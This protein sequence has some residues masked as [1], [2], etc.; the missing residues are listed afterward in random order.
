MPLHPYRRNTNQFIKKRET[1][2]ME[3]GDLARMQQNGT[4][5]NRPGGR[6]HVC[7]H[8]N[9]EVEEGR[10]HIFFIIISG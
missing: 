8:Q 4:K 1:G 5:G 6:R 10:E 2:T 7:V 9:G 3:P